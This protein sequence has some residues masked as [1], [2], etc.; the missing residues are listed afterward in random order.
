MMVLK[1]VFLTALGALGLGALAMNPVFADEDDIPAPNLYDNVNACEMGTTLPGTLTGVRKDRTTSVLGAALAGSFGA[2][3]SFNQINA[4]RTLDLN[5]D[6]TND[7]T[8]ALMELT[9][10][11]TACAGGDPV[12][13]GVAEAVRLYNTENALRPAPGAAPLQQYLDAVAAREDYGGPVYDAV[14]TELGNEQAVRDAITA[15]NNL[16][17]DN[18]NTVNVTEGQYT[19]AL[20]DYRAIRVDRLITS[21]STAATRAHPYGAMG[22]QGFKSFWNPSGAG[23]Q[24]DLTASAVTVATVVLDTLDAG[25]LSNIF[26]VNGALQLDPATTGT[27]GASATINSL[28]LIADELAG[29]NTLVDRQEKQIAAR[30]KNGLS[31]GDDNDRLVLLKRARDHVQSELNRLTV[32][33]RNNVDDADSSNDQSGTETTGQSAIDAFNTQSANLRSARSTLENAVLAFETARTNVSTQLTSTASYL[34]QL[35]DLREWEHRNASEADQGNSKSSVNTNLTAARNQQAIHNS[36]VSDPDNPATDLLNAL[37]EPDTKNN[38]ANTADDDGLA[39]LNAISTNYEKIKEVADSVPDA[40][41]TSAI[42]GRLDTLEGLTAGADTEDAT[43]DGLVTANNNRSTKN[44]NDIT[45]LDGRVAENESDIGQIQTDLY[46][47]TS[48]Q[49]DDLAA[50]DATGLLNVA[51][52]ANARSLHNEA[53][54]AEIDDKL[55]QKKE[56]IDNLGMAIGVDPVTG[57]ATD[58]SGMNKIEMNAAAI[59]AEAMARMEADTALGGRIDA[60]AMARADADEALG[61]RIDAEAMARADADTALG[62][63]IDGEAMARADAD[64]M[65]GGMIM[66]EEMARMEADTA[67]G[68]RISSNADAIASNMNSIGQNASAISDNRNMIGELS[69][70]LDVVR[71]GVA[72]SMALAGMP[73]I[74]GRGI[75]IGVGSYDGESAFAVGFQI[76]GEQA[77]FKVGV[78]SSGGETG[79][80]AGVGFNF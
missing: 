51:N 34:Q 40:L 37:L 73:A 22:T 38:K 6:G 76:Q 80:S 17:A 12:G 28:G 48:G 33:A 64:A 24:T 71:A 26:D 23:S 4:A 70:D 39:L 21:S 42:T 66:S 53:D 29:W 7:V 65:L 18:P 75:S 27:R 15:W 43:D 14:Y 44:A 3:G 49:H 11:T 78:T 67:L 30:T 69:D 5:G 59:D 36:L 25:L 45:S 68:G 41:D 60:E 50:C 32:L 63:R 57:E 8:N 55:M 19:A 1:R 72:A 62:M 58:E 9:T 52:C 74:N 35:V 54:I 2:V 20:T 13:G 31:V 47:E 79:A 77:S 61:G 16:L 46:G 56:Y 10:R